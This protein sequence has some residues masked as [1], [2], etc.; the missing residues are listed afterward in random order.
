MITD[1][2]GFL[3][4]YWQRSSAIYTGQFFA[5]HEQA[6]K[7]KH[8]SLVQIGIRHNGHFRVEHGSLA[9]SGLADDL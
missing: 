7:C 9:V 6:I 1:K 4:C 3:P 5:W 2:R 8:L